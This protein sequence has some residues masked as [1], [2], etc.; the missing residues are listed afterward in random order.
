[1]QETAV[2]ACLRPMLAF[3]LLLLLTPLLEKGLVEL[4]REAGRVGEK[5]PQ[6]HR[7]TVLAQAKR[8]VGG[9]RVVPVH[10]VDNVQVLE[11]MQD[12]PDVLVQR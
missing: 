1:M 12:G 2:D 3:L 5:L 8:R 10:V 9:R 4:I 7:G 6:G 11:L